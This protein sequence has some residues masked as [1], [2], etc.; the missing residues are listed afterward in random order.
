MTLRDRILFHEIHPAKLAT[1]VG[2][3]IVCL[4][5]LWERYLPLAIF[6]AAV[7]PLIASALVLRFA[8]LEALQHSK[9]GIYVHQSMTTAMQVLRLCGFVGMAIG[10]WY[11]SPLAILGGLGIVAV[12]WL[13]GAMSP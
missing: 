1:D 13:K 5:L 10:A 8:D 6:F 2:S 11:H 12:G 9:L 7:P 3:G 4:F